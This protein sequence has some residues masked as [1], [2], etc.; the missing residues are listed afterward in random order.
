MAIHL[1]VQLFELFLL[2]R[3]VHNF[4]IHSKCFERFKLRILE[5]LPKWNISFHKGFVLPS[6]QFFWFFSRL[7]IVKCVCLHSKFKNQPSGK[8]PINDKN[9]KLLILLVKIFDHASNQ[10]FLKF[11]LFF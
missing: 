7:L 11:L 3:F 6:Y 9:F 10:G 2:Q 8:N 4:L 5:L 1:K